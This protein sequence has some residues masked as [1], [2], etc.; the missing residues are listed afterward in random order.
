MDVRKRGFFVNEKPKNPEDLIE[1]DFDN[2]PEMEIPSDWNTQNEQLLFYEGTIWFKKSF[3]YTKNEN[4]KLIL[5]FGAI[6]YESII[7][8]NGILIGKHIGGFT[9]FNFDITSK[10]NR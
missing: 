7:Y 8:I 9:P 3:N 10:I 1:Y 4:K 5:Y 2:A 6:N